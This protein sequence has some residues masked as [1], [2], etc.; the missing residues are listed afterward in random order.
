MGWESELLGFVFKFC[1]FHESKY[2]LGFIRV[3]KNKFA[4][5][6]SMA[7]PNS[8]VQ[9]WKIGYSPK[10]IKEKTMEVRNTNLQSQMR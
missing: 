5:D 4:F 2:I 3:G 10:K 6:Q 7:W 1:N 8:W 9:V